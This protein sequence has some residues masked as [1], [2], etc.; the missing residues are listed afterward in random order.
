MQSGQA[1]TRLWILEFEPEKQ[2]KNDKLLGWV[3][4]DDM[5]SQVKLRFRNK[6]EAITYA[7]RNKIPYGLSEPK[8]RQRRPKSYADNFRFDSAN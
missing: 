3:S 7:E 1:N 4:F 6:E 5:R 2:K 8:I